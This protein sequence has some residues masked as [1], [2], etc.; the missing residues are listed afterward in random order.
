MKSTFLIVLLVCTFS[1]PFNS[2]AHWEKTNL[3]DSLHVWSLIAVDGTTIIAGTN[4]DGIFISGD[5][6]DHGKG[7]EL[8]TLL[9]G[10]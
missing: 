1:L 4:G 7:W 6:G 5:N 3:P 8:S 10:H 9:C 2:I